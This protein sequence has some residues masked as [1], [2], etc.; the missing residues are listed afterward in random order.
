MFETLKVQSAT[1]ILLAATPSLVL[2]A[3]TACLFVLTDLLAAQTEHGPAAL[4]TETLPVEEYKFKTLKVKF[5]AKTLLQTVAQK[6]RSHCA[7]LVLLLA[8]LKARGFAPTGIPTSIPAEMA[9]S[10]VIQQVHSARTVV[11]ELTFPYASSAMLAAAPMAPGLAPTDLPTS[12]YVTVSLS[13]TQM[14]L[15]ATLPNLPHQP[16]H[17]HPSSTW[18]LHGGTSSPKPLRANDSSNVEDV[19]SLLNLV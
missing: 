16:Q 5:V 17:P 18:N 10:L 1:K 6:S 2:T 7:S 9:T 4:E 14:V 15:N 8:A 13:L 19:S 11:H 3:A 12:T